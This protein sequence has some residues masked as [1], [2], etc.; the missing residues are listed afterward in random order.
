LAGEKA[1]TLQPGESVSIAR[2]WLP[3]PAKADRGP[4]RRH[5]DSELRAGRWICFGFSERHER[6][7]RIASP[8]RAGLAFDNSGGMTSA[9]G[10]RY[11]DVLFYQQAKSVAPRQPAGAG[12][13]STLKADLG[14]VYKARRDA[15]LAEHGRYPK[16]DEDRAWGAKQEPKI[17]NARIE[18]LREAHLP[19]KVRKGGRRTS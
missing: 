3:D 19:E 1:Q 13:R 2:G 9:A 12:A 15:F 18:K 5:L 4:L 8:W 11:S 14:S 16:R 6:R 17:T 10:E 7:V